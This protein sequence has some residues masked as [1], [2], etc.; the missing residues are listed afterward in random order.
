MY[1]TYA[2]I[3][4]YSLGSA[5]GIV[6]DSDTITIVLEFSIYSRPYGFNQHHLE[7]IPA[8]RNVAT[9]QTSEVVSRAP[10]NC[11][12]YLDAIFKRHH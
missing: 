4:P 10:K 1:Y 6:A 5:V 8:H 9:S 3:I 7:T 2:I 12:S 11:N